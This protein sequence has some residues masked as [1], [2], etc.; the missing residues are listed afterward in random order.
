MYTVL[1]TLVERL[2]RRAEKTHAE[3][4]A[5]TP[6]QA[7][8]RIDSALST[9][10]IPLNPPSWAVDDSYHEKISTAPVNM[11][12]AGERSQAVTPSAG[13]A[14]SNS[15]HPSR[16]LS[17]SNVLQDIEETSSAESDNIQ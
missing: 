2:D 12:G 9:L 7:K 13:G 16:R 1:N 15:S 8:S 17:L 14:A 5:R 3:S 11:E 6:L 4:L 10:S